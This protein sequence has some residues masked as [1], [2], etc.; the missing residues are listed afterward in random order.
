MNA[1][2]ARRI[3]L[4]S[5]TVA[6]GLVAGGFLLSAPAGAAARIDKLPSH[7]SV[8][9]AGGSAHTPPTVTLK[10]GMTRNIEMAVQLDGLD[11]T[12]DVDPAAAS[13]WFVRRPFVAVV[14]KSGDTVTVTGSSFR[15]NSSN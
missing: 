14:E 11:V 15:V 3:A 9:V 6:G 12:A 2:T 4:R 8:D 13:G 1:T 10:R 5:A 7:I